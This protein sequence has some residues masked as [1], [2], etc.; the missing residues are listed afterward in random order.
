[1]WRCALEFL[2]AARVDLLLS[3]V[4]LLPVVLLAQSVSTSAAPLVKSVQQEPSVF[5]QAIRVATL[6]V[7]SCTW[8]LG[9]AHLEAIAASLR[10]LESLRTAAHLQQ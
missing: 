8:L 1:M 4:V 3:R 9:M 5:A 10:V 6:A 2:W 7:E